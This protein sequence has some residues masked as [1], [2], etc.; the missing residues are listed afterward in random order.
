MPVF[1]DDEVHTLLAFIRESNSLKYIDGRVQR[2]IDVFNK[3]AEQMN[4]RYP[5][6]NKKTGEQIRTKWKNLKKTYLTEKLNA[7]KSGN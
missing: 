4:I 5:D 1:T 7:S 3:L 6:R 2:N